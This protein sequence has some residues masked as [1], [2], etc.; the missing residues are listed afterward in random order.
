MFEYGQSYVA[1][2][3]VKSLEGLC[4]KG[5]MTVDRIKAHPKVKEYYSRMLNVHENVEDV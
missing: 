5:G 4:I 1:L 2:S 3:R